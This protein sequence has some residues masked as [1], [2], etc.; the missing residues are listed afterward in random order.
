[1]DFSQDSP[2]REE[3]W[4]KPKRRPSTPPAPPK[5]PAS[6]PHPS[7]TS[8]STSPSSTSLPH[9]L[10]SSSSSPPPPQRDSSSP[11]L[12]STNE[13]L[14]FVYHS[15]SLDSR[16]EMLLKEQ[17]AKFSFLASDEEDEE[18]RKDEKQRGTRG[19]RGERRGGTGDG[20]GM[21]TGGT[22]T[23]WIRTTGGKV[24]EMATEEGNGEREERVGKVP[25]YLMQPHHPPPPILPI[26]HHQR[27]PSPRLASQGL[28]L[29]SRSPHRLDQLLIHAAGQE[30]THHLIMGRVS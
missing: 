30:H 29:C 19:D 28:E 14:P 2:A 16:I 9:H 25:L 23:V 3:Q 20:T 26:S 21:H 8:S 1:M 11:E 6:S 22:Q 24:T 13:S 18:D 4:T 7:I 27:N 5:T 10:P 15:S 17:K 12:D